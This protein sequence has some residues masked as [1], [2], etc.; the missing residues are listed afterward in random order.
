MLNG[1]RGKKK[2]THFTKEPNRK[3]VHLQLNGNKPK[4]WLFGQQVDMFNLEKDY[5]QILYLISSS[6]TDHTQEEKQM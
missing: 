1:N 5:K 2:I 3:K 4:H 6:N